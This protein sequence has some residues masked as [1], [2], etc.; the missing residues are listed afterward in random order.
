MRAHRIYGTRAAN[1]TGRTLIFCCL[2]YTVRQDILA[3][4]RK[5]PP[6][7]DGRKLRFSP[8]YSAHTLRRRLAFS[9]VMDQARTGGIEFFLIYPATLKIKSRAGAMETFQCP[10]KAEEYLKLL[11]RGRPGAEDGDAAN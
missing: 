1:V 2:R 8:D 6:V 11:L 4:A 7:V 3:A 9:S 5:N 10:R